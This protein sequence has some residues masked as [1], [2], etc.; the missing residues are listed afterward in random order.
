MNMS[1]TFTEFKE[2]VEKNKP[3][4]FYKK[5]IKGEFK[6]YDGLSDN[7]PIAMFFDTF[8]LAIRK[9]R[10]YFMFKDI[11]NKIMSSLKIKERF[12]RKR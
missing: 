1:M 4:V 8:V 12:L 11:V 7:S 9:T 6:Y 5:P 10:Y 2:R 3:I